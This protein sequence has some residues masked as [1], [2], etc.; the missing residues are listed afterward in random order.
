VAWGVP[1]VLIR[2]NEVG[3]SA[4]RL[5]RL[6]DQGRPQD[7]QMGQPPHSLIAPS[8]SGVRPER[9]GRHAHPMRARE[10]EGYRHVACCQS[11]VVTAATSSC[12]LQP[13]AEDQ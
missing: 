11:L 2:D 9:K 7:Q 4:I 10:H 3:L 13:A 12:T 1:F 5:H 6:A 8:G